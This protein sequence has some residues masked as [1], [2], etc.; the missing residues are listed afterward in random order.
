MGLK[1]K[2]TLV[3]ITIAL[4]IVVLLAASSLATFRQFSLSTAQE[5]ARVAAEIVRLYLT[6]S[7]VHGTIQHREAF[8]KRLQSVEGLQ[9]ARVV[10]SPSVVKQHGQGLAGESDTDEIEEQVLQ[11][12][13]PFYGLV[14]HQG[15]QMFRATIPYLA[16]AESTPNCLQC[17]D[18]K[19]G[20]ALGAVTLYISIDKQ[21]QTGI[22]S[23]AVMTVLLLIF[24]LIA[25]LFARRMITPL[26]ELAS[27]IQLVVSN[28]RQGDFSTRLKSQGEDELGQIGRDL[29]GHLDYMEEGLNT[30]S[31]QVADLMRYERRAGGDVFSNTLSMVKSL[32]DASHYKQA[33]EED[34]TAEEVY[35]RLIKIFNE[36]F[37]LEYFSIYE[38]DATNNRLQ[39][40]SATCDNGGQCSWCD[41]DIMVRADTCRARRTGR[42]VN[43][44]ENP[45]ICTAFRPVVKEGQV[46]RHVCIPIIQSGSVGAV[47]QLISREERLEQLKEALP[48]IQVFLR[49]TAPVLEAKRLTAHLRESALSDAMT[50]LHNRR[51]LEEYIDTL[52]SYTERHKTSFSV[53]MLDLDYFKKVNDT[54][55]HEAGDEV[56]RQVAKVIKQQLRSSDIIVRYG[57]EEFLAVIRDSQ[58]GTGSAVAEKIRSAVADLKIQLPGALLQK[59][60]SIGVAE[61]PDDSS[62]V[63]QVIKYADVALYQAKEN[64]R[65]QV[66]SFTAEMWHDQEEF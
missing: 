60:I 7:M 47:V 35:G 15:M 55:G 6:E 29:N 58:K 25:V 21:K 16:M 42:L 51:F 23:A 11:S 32:V 5:R 19:P 20:S 3:F 66:V 33:I 48:Y 41:P 17:H 14:N 18:V 54:Y 57:G 1:T 61:Y 31:N 27:D 62:S 59:T 64:G 38:M 50:G 53:L 13:Q 46:W 22:T 28:A 44:I 37:G 52:A 40:V 63:W 30:I 8:F 2:I 45:G 9:S 34:E 24:T 12:S 56:L 39:S 26:L 43:D 10:R 49:E 36:H 4:V 65:N